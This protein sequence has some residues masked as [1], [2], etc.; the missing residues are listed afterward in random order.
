M[1]IR[2]V[3]ICLM[4][5]G[6]SLSGC[7]AAVGP[8]L[9]ASTAGAATLSMGTIWATSAEVDRRNNEER[10]ARLA[11]AQARRDTNRRTQSAL[12]AQQRP[13]PL[14]SASLVTPHAVP[15]ANGAER[16]TIKD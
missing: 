2:A 4:L 7:I 6:A 14:T 5:I 3:L 11:A 12:R 8:A 15:I 10:E 9:M 13:V 16:P 1:K